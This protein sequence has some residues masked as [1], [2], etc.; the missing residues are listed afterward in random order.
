MNRYN[1]T[2]TEARWDGKQ[3]YTT[4]T[5]PSIPYLPNDIYIISQDN[6]YLDQL[7]YIYYSDPTLWWIIAQANSL[8]KGR[9]SVPAGIQLRI[10]ANPT[11]VINNLKTVNS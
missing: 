4:L 9:L 5:M 2:G 1:Y 3:V 8:G 10:P 6:M 11:N 7:A